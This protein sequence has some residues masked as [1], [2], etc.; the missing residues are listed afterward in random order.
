MKLSR[1]TRRRLGLYGTALVLAVVALSIPAIVKRRAPH[2]PVRVFDVPAAL[3]H[4][5]TR[6][7]IDY[8]RIDTANPPGIT[9]EAIRL[10]AN[11][12]ACEGI[13]YE[14]VGPDPERPILVARLLSP[15]RGGGLM[16][17]HHVDVAP[18]GDLSQWRVPP[19]AGQ[20]GVGEDLYYLFGRGTLDL[21]SLG[22]ASFF[23]M[24]DLRRAGITPRRDVVYVAESSEESREPEKG[25]GWLLRN[26][27]DLVEG[28]TDVYNEGGIAEVITSEI[29]RFLIETVQKAAVS[30]WIDG[31]TEEALLRFGELVDR[32]DKELPYRLLPVARDYLALP[33]QSRGAY[34]EV[35]LADPDK[36]IR[37]GRAIHLP[38]MYRSFMKDRYL[39]GKPW[40]N[41]TGGFSMRVVATLLPGS[42]VAAF[43]SRV[44]GWARD[45]RLGVRVDYV[46]DDS[47]ESPRTGA[48]WNA[49]ETALRLDHPA[50]VFGHYIQTTAYTNNHYLRAR[51]LRAYGVWPFNV[52]LFDMQK[53]HHLN[54]RVNVVYFVEGVERMTRI[55]REFATAP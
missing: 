28:V 53:I 23:A 34:L 4:P 10:L 26:R 8:V 15:A 11:A 27:P 32:H 51:G 5:A 52:N 1:N 33:H 14:I 2:V 35:L 43:R 55:V 30:L 37:D 12:F 13:P 18:V 31:P 3:A 46:N 40:R 25:V 24:A 9:R 36:A 41:P 38:E 19:F 44:E 48:A 16:L 20:M 22:V 6:M 54:E 21:K 49:L 45:A 7:L 39:V 17:L 29:E 47:F 42:P 50:A